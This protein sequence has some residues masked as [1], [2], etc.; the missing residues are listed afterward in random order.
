MFSMSN[1]IA[2]FFLWLSTL[3]GFVTVPCAEP[4]TYSV[5]E[6]DERFGLSRADFLAAL[7]EAE[8]VWEKELSSNEKSPDRELFSLVPEKGAISVHLVYD[9][10]QEATQ[11]LSNITTTL[12]DGQK[13]YAQLE[14]GYLVLKT[15]TEALKSTYDTA[16][17]AFDAANGVYSRHVAEWNGGPR[18]SKSDLEALE[19]E[20]MALEA[21][22][23]ALE[24]RRTELNT[25][26]GRLNALAR[27]LNALADN[28]NL[29][30][31]RYNAVG[32]SRGEEFA[33]GLYTQEGRSRRIDIFEFQTHEKLVRVLAHELGHA[34]GLEHVLDEDAIMHAV[35]E[36][37]GVRATAAD[38]TALKTLCQVQ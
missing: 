8:A 7:S 12:T 22:Q 25:E 15:R 13:Q 18:T 6:M 21:E 28:L 34:L 1:A 35:N 17:T 5:V 23:A 11:R 9:Y 4:V 26:V 20:R 30:V 32:A 27:Q 38:V 10:R 29:N 19:R 36:G 16:A 37:E 33:G 31:R 14:K 2:S 3:L 24:V